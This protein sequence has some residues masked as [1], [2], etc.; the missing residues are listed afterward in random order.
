MKDVGSKNIDKM[1]A[2][3]SW[4]IFQIVLKR[5]FTCA[6]IDHAGANQPLPQLLM[7]QLDFLPS[8]YRHISHMHGEI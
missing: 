8:Q 5:G 7:D 2:M 3:R 1:T 6:M 4:T